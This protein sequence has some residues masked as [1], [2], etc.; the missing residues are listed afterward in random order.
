M[1]DNGILRPA[2]NFIK[3]HGVAIFLVVFFVVVIYPEQAD[4]R[5]DW[6]TQITKLQESLDPSKRPITEDQATIILDLVTESFVQSIEASMGQLGFG[7]IGQN[8]PFSPQTIQGNQYLSAPL[9]DD[10]QPFRAFIYGQPFTIDRDE[11]NIEDRVQVL[12]K[13]YLRA[14]KKQSLL[15]SQNIAMSLEKALRSSRFA[16]SGLR[17]FNI[18]DSTL[19]DYWEV[20]FN[21]HYDNFHSNLVQSYIDQAEYGFSRD[22]FIGFIE[23]SG[24]KVPESIMEIKKYKQPSQVMFDFKTRLKEEWKRSLAETPVSSSPLEWMSEVITNT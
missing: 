5:K 16:T 15:V 3:D 19:L 23:V 7:Y 24:A 12:H 21:K 13:K 22:Q 17:N 14:A 2:G 6:I 4:E 8:L 10:S 18:K 20:A 1:S 9:W 11:K